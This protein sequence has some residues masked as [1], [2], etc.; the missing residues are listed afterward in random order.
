M[1]RRIKK[2]AAMH[3]ACL[4]AS[5]R[6]A[7]AAIAECDAR[8]RSFWEDL[9]IIGAQRSREWRFRLEWLQTDHYRRACAREDV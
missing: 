4:R 7:L 1:N 9:A 2:A 3:A 8:R 5:Y 6:N